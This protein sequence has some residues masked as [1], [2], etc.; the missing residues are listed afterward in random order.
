MATAT[1]WT[2]NTKSTRRRTKWNKY[3]LARFPNPDTPFADWGARTGEPVLT[4]YYV[5]HNHDCFT[6]AGDCSD[7]LR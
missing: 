6:K 1:L 5:H 4:V 2:T 7:R 3:G